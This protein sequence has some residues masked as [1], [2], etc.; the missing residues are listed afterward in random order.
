[1]LKKILIVLAAL[2]VLLVVVIAMQPS[3]FRVARTATV[4]A[5]APVV[6]AQ[7]NDFHKW[8][9]WNPWAK[10]DPTMKQSYAGA[11]SGTGAVYTWAGKS[12]VGEG[13]LTVTESRPSDLIRIRL[14]FLKPFAGTSVAEFTFK[15]EGDQTAVV[16]SMT[17]HNNFIAKALCL[18]MNMDKMIGGQFEKGLAQ[19]K[20]A[21]EAAARS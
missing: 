11:P 15:P 8:E 9:A 12:E 19:M 16:W 5:L 7:V 13:R 3:E 6:F 21:A 2:V 14:D 4:D 18:F 10:M 20:V 17:G 1:M